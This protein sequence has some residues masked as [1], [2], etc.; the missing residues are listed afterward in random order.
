MITNVSVVGVYVRDEL[1]AL[2]F[3]TDILGFKQHTYDAFGDYLE[4]PKGS[5]EFGNLFA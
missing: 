4:S 3:Y 1:A 2:K 5:A